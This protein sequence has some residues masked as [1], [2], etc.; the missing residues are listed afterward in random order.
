MT[1]RRRAVPVGRF[2]APIPRTRH[3][4]QAVLHRQVP[5]HH[6]QFKQFLD[7]THYYAPRDPGNFLRDWKNGTYPGMGQ[8]PVTWVSLEDARAYAAWA[9]KRLP[10]EWEWQFAA[11]GT[12]RR[13]FRGATTGIPPTSPRQTPG[14]PCTVLNL[15]DAHPQG[16]QPVRRAGSGGQRLAMDRRIRGRAH[17]G[18]DPSRR[19]LL[20]AAGF[21]LVF[22]AGLS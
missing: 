10:R 22:S 6:A 15:S 21:H 9:G 4:D 2:C 14:E 11:Q 3:D 17:A 20:S 19:Q 5:R 16:S 12:D 1:W 18:R 13:V 8:P 7:A